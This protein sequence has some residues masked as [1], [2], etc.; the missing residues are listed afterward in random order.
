MFVLLEGMN[1]DPKHLNGVIAGL[2][3]LYE[4]TGG[5]VNAHVP[6]P[7]FRRRLRGEYRQY[8]SRMLRWLR[9]YGFAYR[10]GG[11]D[12]WGVTRVGLAYLRSLGLVP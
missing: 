3:A 11:T 9:R 2:L 5:S 1:V 8:S 7:A 6:E 4:A 10:K 12:S